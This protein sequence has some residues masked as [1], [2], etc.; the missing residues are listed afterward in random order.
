MPAPPGTGC[1]SRAATRSIG[2]SLS[3]VGGSYGFD[4]I[5]RIGKAIEEQSK[6][7]DAAGVS[8]LAAQLEDYLTRVQPEYR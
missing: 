8:G 6:R 2:H 1:F 5:T 7:G 3:G 4:E